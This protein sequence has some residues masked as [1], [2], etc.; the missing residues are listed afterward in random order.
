MR[1]LAALL[2]AVHA[3][4]ACTSTSPPAP[5]ATPITAPAASLTITHARL[6]GG[7]RVD[8]ALAAGRIVAIR[9]P[10]AAP[11]GPV[12][13]A[14]DRFL[15]PQLIDAHVHLAYLPRGPELLAH[16]IV[17]AVDLGAPSLRDPRA[18]ADGPRLVQAGPMLTIPGGYPLDSWGSDGFGLGLASPAAASAAVDDLAARGASLIK[19][20]VFDERGLD[21]A[22]LAAV[23]AAAHAHHLL[24]AAHALSDRDAARAA[25]AGC[26]LL[27]HTPIEPLADATVAAWHDRT[28]ISTLGAFGASPAAVDNLARLH[29]AGARVLYGTDFGNAQLAGI[30]G[31]ELALLVRAGLT[32]AQA[33]AAATSAPAALFHLDDLGTVRVG[34]SAAILLLD[35]DP[36]VDPTT[37]AH[38]WR[39]IR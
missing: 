19:V 39:V 37:L 3:L 22:R 4:A 10:G 9:S 2:L 5:R 12:L 18:T 21:D 20:V 30:D 1:P 15:A 7:E 33:F 29:A 32:P 13:D 14:H 31:D 11:S 28:V 6:P 36:S 8:V 26:D 23:V 25:A 17:A 27:A 38:P 24:V 35:A 16:G 34:A